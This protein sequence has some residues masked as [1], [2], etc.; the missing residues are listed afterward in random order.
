MSWV[1]SHLKSFLS[2]NYY[3]V[4]RERESRVTIRLREVSGG[5][6]HHRYTAAAAGGA[7]ASVVRYICL[8]EDKRRRLAFHIRGVSDGSCDFGSVEEESIPGFGKTD[9][10]K[11]PTSEKTSVP[12]PAPRVRL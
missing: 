2:V 11:A 8:R 9:I 6:G 12:F 5:R 7:T 1:S 3:L 10:R 4:Y